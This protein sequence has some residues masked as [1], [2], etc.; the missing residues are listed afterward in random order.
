MLGEQVVFHLVE[1]T[2]QVPTGK[3]YP[4]HDYVPTGI[5]CFEIGEWYTQASLKDGKRKL[6]ERLNDFIVRLL[7][8]AFEDRKR[9]EARER[10]EAIRREQAA[11]VRDC[12]GEAAGR[13]E[14]DRAVGCLD[15]GVA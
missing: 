14:E 15:D 7:E 4:R 13:G 10:D 12:G 5:L 9:R 2:K 8:E 11:V 3:E 6:E 1:R